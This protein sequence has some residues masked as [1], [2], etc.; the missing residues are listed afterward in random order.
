MRLVLPLAEFGRV[1]R[2]GGRAV[3]STPHPSMDHQ[4]AGRD[5]YFEAYGFNDEWLRAAG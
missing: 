3:L 4:L 1:P 2:Q 5:D